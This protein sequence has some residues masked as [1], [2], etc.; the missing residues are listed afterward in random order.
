MLQHGSSI[1]TSLIHWSAYTQYTGYMFKSD[2]LS[3]LPSWHIEHCMAHRCLHG[4]VT[5]YL[6]RWYANSIKTQISHGWSA[7]C[8]ILPSVSNWMMG[9]SGP[10]RKHLEQFTHRLHLCFISGF[11]QTFKVCSIAAV[12]LLT[13]HCVRYTVPSVDWSATVVLVIDFYLGH[14]KNYVEDNDGMIIVTKLIIYD[15]ICCCRCC[16]SDM[17][18]VDSVSHPLFFLLWINI[19]WRLFCI[20]TYILSSVGCECVAFWLHQ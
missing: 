12:T 1:D 19:V 3:E 8:A 9:F 2:S 16:V 15:W 18:S 14:F 6:C 17:L 10:W 20:R 11:F 7:H 13:F 4:G 5:V